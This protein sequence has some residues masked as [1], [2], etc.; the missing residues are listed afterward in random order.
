MAYGN[1][2]ML[3]LR[4]TPSLP[5]AAHGTRRFW[6]IPSSSVIVF[7]SSYKAHLIIIARPTVAS[8]SL[9]AKGSRPSRC[10]RHR[11]TDPWSHTIGQR[12]PGSHCRRHYLF[13]GPPLP[14]EIAEDLLNENKN[15]LVR[16]AI[17]ASRA[18]PVLAAALENA[19]AEA[20]SKV[21]S[22]ASSRERKGCAGARSSAAVCSGRDG[23]SPIK[24]VTLRGLFADF[25]YCIAKYTRDDN[26]DRCGM[27]LPTRGS[28]FE[29]LDNECSAWVDEFELE[30]SPGDKIMYGKE[31]LKILIEEALKNTGYRGR[32][33]AIQNCLFMVLSAIT[34]LRPSSFAP[35]DKK[36][37]EKKKYPIIQNV[38]VNLIGP[39]AFSSRLVINHLKGHNGDIAARVSFA[40]E[41]V[42]Y[43]YNV[44]FDPT[45][46]FLCFFIMRDVLDKS[47]DDV[48][49][50]TDF[51]FGYTPGCEKQPLFLKGA[52]GHFPE[53][54]EV[55][56]SK[57]LSQAVSKIAQNRGMAWTGSYAFRRAIATLWAKILNSEHA[58]RLL[59]H[60]LDAGSLHNYV[61]GSS[62]H[63][64]V[65]VALLE[66]AL[67]DEAKA[68]LALGAMRGQAVI[69]VITLLEPL[70]KKKDGIVQN[71]FTSKLDLTTAQK[72]EINQTPI[73]QK[74]VLERYKLLDELKALLIISHNSNSNAV[75]EGKSQIKRLLSASV[76]KGGVTEEQCAHCLKVRERLCKAFDDEVA[77]RRQLCR[78]LILRLRQDRQKMLIDYDGGSLAERKG[79]QHDAE[80][81]SSILQDI[82]AP[83]DS[84]AASSFGV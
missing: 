52:Q 15:R 41:P 77:I 82:I 8:L 54:V 12:C 33:L 73:M 64:L 60:G 59:A 46:W 18:D 20:L 79:A 42:K 71:Q 58:D 70:T 63:D 32:D 45:V 39:L 67:T 50:H 3:N 27:A 31:E 76:L 35:S 2:K 30:R 17:D 72:E 7:T 83:T 68:R 75:Y 36:L 66:R 11:W 16:T 78:E 14:K 40:L 28:H 56:T 61:D 19:F 22:N 24:A 37:K 43:W 47:A 21:E 4:P 81:P 80:Q 34:G 65:A 48:E 55:T 69:A 6:A 51:T 57:Q 13:Q 74:L 29:T 84:T 26:G 49:K 62:T 9:K 38:K 25:I 44:I 1:G 10:I 53:E 5:T 23:K